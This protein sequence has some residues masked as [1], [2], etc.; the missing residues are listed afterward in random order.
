MKKTTAK[1]VISTFIIGFIFWILITGQAVSILNGKASAEILAAGALVCLAAACFSARFFIHER[2]F[3]LFDPRRLG[4]FLVYCL[5]IFPV[6]LIR[7]NVDM[8]FRALSPKLRIDPGIVKIPVG[9]SSEYGQA[10]LADSITLTP[11]TITM[12]VAE[13]T[14]D[15][16]KT[17][18]YIHWID[19]SAE[20]PQA[21][22]EAIKGGMEKYIRRIWE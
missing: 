11:G 17:Y 4:A 18:F 7:A 13:D 5:I 10:M 21:A 9:L 14:E 6:E 12:D 8:A 16:N 22:G 20:D 19:A 15:D 2:A 1:A 3:H